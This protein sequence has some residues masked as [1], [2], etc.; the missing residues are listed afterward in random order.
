MVDGQSSVDYT[1][2]EQRESPRMLAGKKREEG[3]RNYPIIAW[4]GSSEC[5]K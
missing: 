4:V 3:G 2:V 5:Q 1:A